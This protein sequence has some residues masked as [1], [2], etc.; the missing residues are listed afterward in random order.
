VRRRPPLTRA[1]PDATAGGA[2]A[3]PAFRSDCMLSTSAIPGRS[4]S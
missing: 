3:W 4:R 1:S 2:A